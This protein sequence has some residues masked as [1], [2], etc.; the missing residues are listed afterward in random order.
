[1]KSKFTLKKPLIVKKS[2]KNYKQ[3]SKILKKTG[4]SPGEL[5]NLDTTF[6]TFVIPRL[7]RFKKVIRTYP[8]SL[9]NIDEWFEIIDKMILAHSLIVY[10]DAENNE[11]INEGLELFFK[12]YHYLWQ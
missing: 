1:M 4:I 6:S 10:Y 3:H 5:V 9:N 8:S 7:K 11:K 12:Y 2:D